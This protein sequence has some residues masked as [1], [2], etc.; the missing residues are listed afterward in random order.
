M[1]KLSD[2]I[3][4]LMRSDAYL[5]SNNPN[6]AAVSKQVQDYF[7]SKYRNSRTDITGRNITIRTAWR[8]HT[9]ID[10]RTCDDCL[11][12]SDT[13]YENI[14][15]IPENPHHPNC[16]CWIQEIELDD[17][18]NFADDERRAR[19]VRKGM[20]NEGGYVD[21]P[22][23]IDQPTNIGV[24]QPTLNKY[25]ADHP[26]FNFPEKVK[27]LSPE[28]VQ[29]IYNEDYYDERRIGE[30]E[31]ERIATAIFDMGLMSNFTN[32]GKMVQETLNNSIGE[33]LA[34]DGKM[35]NDTIAALN[36]IPDDN[37][38]KFMNDLKENRLE[39][40][41]GLSDWEKYG[42]GWANRT[43]KY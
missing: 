1:N 4:N 40:L 30:I 23:K 17:D 2:S 5:N 9:E 26:N 41:Q 42:D 33:N 12:F 25:N 6:H 36:S 14:E 38:D 7:E 34:V 15:D 3:L 24:T 13:V 39:Y 10:E 18:D 43:N 8:W 29:Q 31:N 22:R 28:Q 37:L 19:I 16:R 35:G 20:K 21:D 27:D 32:V 11:S